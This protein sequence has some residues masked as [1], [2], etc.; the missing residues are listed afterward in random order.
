[1]RTYFIEKIVRRDE[2]SIL[3]SYHKIIDTQLLELTLRLFLKI[4]F[5]HKKWIN[6]LQ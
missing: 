4:S 2:Q 6:Y 1:M 3:V 5:E